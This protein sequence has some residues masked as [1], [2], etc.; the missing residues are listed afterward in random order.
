MGRPPTSFRERLESLNLNFVT[1]ET[2]GGRRFTGQITVQGDH[3]EMKQSGTAG[4]T[5]HA[6]TLIPIAHIASIELPRH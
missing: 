5:N 1:I 2:S 4:T 3:I 6:D